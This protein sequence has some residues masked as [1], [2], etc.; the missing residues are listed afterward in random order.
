MLQI[1]TAISSMN[2]S[3][4]SEREETVDSAL[5][6]MSA[7]GMIDILTKYWREGTTTD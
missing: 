6:V 1:Q 4:S 2:L 7:E 5:L 3:Y